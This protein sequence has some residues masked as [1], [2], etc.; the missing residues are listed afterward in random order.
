MLA[1]QVPKIAQLRNMLTQSG[2][3]I[4]LAVEGGIDPG[5]AP[6]AIQ[7]GAD[8]LIAGSAVYGKPDYTAAI[9]ALK[10]V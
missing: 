10:D 9:S 4:R 6:L 5:T 3:S 8:V 1:S 2:R 7:A